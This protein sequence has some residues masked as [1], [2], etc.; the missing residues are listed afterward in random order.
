MIDNVM[1]RNQLPLHRIVYHKV[2]LL[3]CLDVIEEF[4]MVRT[5]DY[6]LL[7][8]EVSSR[9]AMLKPFLNLI[10]AKIVIDEL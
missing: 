4:E 10:S 8:S 6:N 9:S 3:V 5:C 1:N 7:V 2:V